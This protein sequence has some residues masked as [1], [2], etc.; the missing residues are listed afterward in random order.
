MSVVQ[1]LWVGDELTDLEIYSIKSFI[2]VGHIFHLYTYNK[3]KNLPKSRKLKIKDANTII[4]KNELFDFKKSYLPFAD[5]FRY[6]LLY[7][8]G[9]YWVDL[10]MIEIK[11]L[12]FKEPYI[13]SS[14]KTIQKGA[15]KN[16]NHKELANIGV[17]KAPKK[18]PFYKE[19]YEEC[20]EKSK[21]SENIQYMRIMRK[22]LE[23][24]KFQKYVKPAKF[25]CPLDWWHT[26][27]AFYPVC[28]K[29]KYDVSG[30]TP[31]SLFKQ[32][33]TIHM[34]RSIMK[35][36]HEIDINQKFDDNSIWEMCKRYVDNGSY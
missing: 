6:K 18:S 30:Y 16:V 25:F 27:D 8:N 11:K 7:E 17:L 5:L 20:L 23:Q 35:K 10:D 15:Y 3:I 12:D 29:S 22:I 32:P 13:F 33:Y 21:I 14:E 19:L 9:G 2:N 34:W 36:R 1:S 26:K 24:Y 31:K 4:K 28:C